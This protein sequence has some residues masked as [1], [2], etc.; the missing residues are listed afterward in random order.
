[1]ENEEKLNPVSLEA[2]GFGVGFL[3]RPMGMFHVSVKFTMSL[4][5]SGTDTT[6]Q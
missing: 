2:V 3:R 6:G 5:N 1:M 4:E